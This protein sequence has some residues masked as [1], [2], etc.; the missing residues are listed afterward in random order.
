MSSEPSGS[1]ILAGVRVLEWGN[2]LLGPY[3]AAILGYLGADVIKIEERVSGD[4]MRRSK[5]AYEVPM[6]APGGRNY[7]FEAL[8]LNKR[9]IAL[10]LKQEEGRQIVY[11]LVNLS[12][13]F[14]TNYRHSA[15]LRLGLDYE[16]L[17][18]HN[19][20][21]IYVEA[22]AWGPRGPDADLP[23][24]NMVAQSRSGIMWCGQLGDGEQ[25][26]GPEGV[27]DQIGAITTAFGVV[28][29]LL[30][31]DR[32][33]VGQRLCTSL[34]G[35]LLWL[36][37]LT[38]TVQAM[39]GQEPVRNQERGKVLNPLANFYHTADGKWLR[40][41][42]TL[43]ADR[44]WPR[45]CQAVG[46]AELEHD[47]RFHSQDAREK[48]H[49]ELIA[50]L[51]HIFQQRPRGEWL[52]AFKKWDL[53]AAPVNSLADVL[54]DVQVK[55]NN[56]IVEHPHPVLGPLRYVG[57]PIEFSHTPAAIKS[58]APELGQHTE[59]VL[60][61]VGGYAQEEVRRLRERGVV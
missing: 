21:L 4:P 53:A 20:Q 51:D 26:V 38:L 39:T 48:N 54:D 27:G 46:I 41:N 13:V 14:I 57:F 36:Q 55:E 47:P 3:T 22:S 24:M 40:I 18:R 29:A 25:P 58:V 56:Y 23:G 5:T 50:I 19:A 44:W 52:E 10:D 16:T 43:E 28:C 1:P 30:A 17:K 7:M 9:G 33:G 37:N 49:K 8:N 2:R 45:F 11:R 35:S 61:E 42:L 15:A 12:D 60:I 59:E 6:A 31:R 32:H 34:L